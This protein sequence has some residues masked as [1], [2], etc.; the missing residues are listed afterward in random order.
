MQEA[1][2]NVVRHSGAAAVTVEV[3]LFP[4]EVIVRVDDDGTAAHAD[5]AAGGNGVRGMRERA[6]SV[7]G[8]LT[9]APNPA[10]GFRVWARLPL[11][12]AAEPPVAGGTRDDSGLG[13]MEESA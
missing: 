12:A 3:R 2:T 5:G 13:D 9:A 6:A 11:D 10:G 7:G 4:G 8:E 1:L